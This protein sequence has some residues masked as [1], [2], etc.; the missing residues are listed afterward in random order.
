MFETYKENM[1][2]YL[3]FVCSSKPTQNQSISVINSRKDVNAF[4]NETKKLKKLK[5][6]FDNEKVFEPMKPTETNID[7]KIKVDMI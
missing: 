3:D 1:E 6:K 4:T 2:Q 7:F 5:D